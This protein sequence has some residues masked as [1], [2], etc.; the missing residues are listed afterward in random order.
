MN[1]EWLH[2]IE[3]P[4]KSHEWLQFSF[5]KEWISNTYHREVVQVL[6][7]PFQSL[8]RALESSES[9]V[10]ASLVQVYLHLDEGQRRKVI[11]EKMASESSFFY[12]QPFES[13]QEALEY[14]NWYLRCLASVSGHEEDDEALARARLAKMP[15]DYVDL[16][17]LCRLWQRQAFV[18]RLD[19]IRRFGSEGPELLLVH[20]RRYWAPVLGSKRPLELKNRLVV[21]QNLQG[22]RAESFNNKS[23][24]LCPMQK[25]DEGLHYVQVGHLR[26]PMLRQQLQIVETQLDE[27]EELLGA[28]SVW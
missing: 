12:L 14:W 26:L 1:R 20:H 22:T 10:R 27:A 25:H 3:T 18:F 11:E 19:G 6:A 2:L 17:L 13:V 16:E 9:V 5:L 7:C 21:L 28:R 24:W 8:A 23:G 4:E 15:L